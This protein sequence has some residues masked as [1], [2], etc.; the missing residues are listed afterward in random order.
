MF[1]AVHAGDNEELNKLF[2]RRS[3]WMLRADTRNTPGI[4]VRGLVDSNRYAPSPFQWREVAA[5]LSA[6][7]SGKTENFETAAAVDNIS[8][9]T[10]V[11]EDDTRFGYRRYL[12]GSATRATQVITFCQGLNDRLDEIPNER[13]DIPHDKAFMYVGY[14]ADVSKPSLEYEQGMSS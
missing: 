14:S 2:A 1:R 9:G 5:V 10:K 8:R 13:N 12:N 11:T 3:E 7:V 6:Y 4:Y